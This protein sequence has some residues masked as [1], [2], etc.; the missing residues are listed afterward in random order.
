[1]LTVIRRV[2]GRD[3]QEVAGVPQPD[4]T[5]D[6][7]MHDLA[8]AIGPPGVGGE[9]LAAARTAFGWRPVDADLDLA[10]LRYDSTFDGPAPV[11]GPG[12]GSPRT[13]VFRGDRLG[14]E[15]ELTGAGIE[16][17]LVPP[18][19]GQVRLLTTS[20]VAVTTTA[21]DAGCFAFPAEAQNPPRTTG[22]ARR[23]GPFRIE[24]SLAAGRFAT[25]WIT[26]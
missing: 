18:E 2:A 25:Q 20:G 7:L 8:Q 16:G 13:L 12:S 6:E 9:L 24:G 21:D 3:A 14:V 23:R 4:W 15:I 5:D 19:P 22:H 1:M 17:Q 11:R 26:G 10:E